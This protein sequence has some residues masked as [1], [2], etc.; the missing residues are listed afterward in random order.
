M[1]GFTR[2]QSADPVRTAVRTGAALLPASDVA[3][4]LLGVLFVPVVVIL[5]V[6]LLLILAVTYSF[7]FSLAALPQYAARASSKASADGKNISTTKG[8]SQTARLVLQMRALGS[9]MGFG[10]DWMAPLFALRR[11]SHPSTA[12]YAGFCVFYHLVTLT[13]WVTRRSVMSV[14]SLLRVTPAKFA[15]PVCYHQA[16]T[17]WLDDAVYEF[18]ERAGRD[19][20]AGQPQVVVLGAGYDSRAYRF[21]G[22]H[23]FEVD[24][25]GTQQC[26]TRMLDT[27]GIDRRHVTFVPVDFET[28]C[29]LASLCDA[30]FDSSA[31]AC[32]IVEG[33]SYYLTA[34][35]FD[36]TLS[37][38]RRCAAG[39]VTC[40]DY[41]TPA[42]AFDPH[43]VRMMRRAG[44]P[45]K[46]AMSNNDSD[47]AAFLGR[48]NLR[49]TLL[50]NLKIDEL[51][52]RYLPLRHGR[53]QR[54]IGSFDD[55]GGFVVATT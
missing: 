36:A 41:F 28:D 52:A 22:V 4:A 39:S 17:C 18:L 53:R 11:E 26:K 42:V 44:E 13:F 25:L 15:D 46:F 3:D 51:R 49:L 45:L 32:F 27:L 29:W 48:P 47:V 35:A 55:F 40:F 54:C 50:E 1:P 2:A 43:V 38:V 10:P 30:G 7:V 31:P 33:V 21:H 20:G 14:F 34:S 5:C 9:S 16:R 8:G 37:K 19:G 12:A 24:A 6:P 23:F